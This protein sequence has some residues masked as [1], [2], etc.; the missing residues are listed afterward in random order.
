MYHQKLKKLI[1]SGDLLKKTATLALI[2]FIALLLPLNGC[3]TVASTRK[4]GDTMVYGPEKTQEQYSCASAKRVIL[5]LEEVQ[6]LPEV[7]P[8]EKEINHRI[9]YALCPYPRTEILGGDIV[10]V[11]RFNQRGVF[12]DAAFYQFKPG[13]WIV[14]AF[15]GIPKGA[16]SSTYTIGTAMKY[17]K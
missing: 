10:R 14:D 7:V 8:S 6:I 2:G 11:V 1:F 5:Q 16:R 13:T 4:E 17:K 3:T 15:I 12:R 9:R